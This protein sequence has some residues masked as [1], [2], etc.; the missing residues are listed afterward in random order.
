MCPGG[1]LGAMAGAGGG[2]RLWERERRGGGRGSRCPCPAG[3]FGGVAALGARHRPRSCRPGG[4]AARVDGRSGTTWAMAMAGSGERRQRW[5]ST[6]SGWTR[7]GGPGRAGGAVPGLA[8][9]CPGRTAELPLSPRRTRRCGRC[10]RPAR[11]GTRPAMG[12]GS[13]RRCRPRMGTG[14]AT[15]AGRCSCCQVSLGT[16]P[17]VSALGFGSLSLQC[18]PVWSSRSPHHL[19]HGQNPA[20]RGVPEGDDTLPALCAAP[21]R[22]LGL[23]SSK[24]ASVSDGRSKVQDWELLSDLPRLG[25]GDSAPVIA[26]GG[27]TCLC[28]TPRYT[29]TVLDVAQV[30]A[31][32]LWGTISHV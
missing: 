6:A 11:P 28:S 22:R 30:W 23:V 15:T 8:G 27:W 26:V 13:T 7:C 10:R 18:W 24:D 2:S 16:C 31:H 5:S 9:P 21:G 17:G 1:G 29:V 3:R 12:C 32:L 19:P 25:E 20:A 4:C 14:R